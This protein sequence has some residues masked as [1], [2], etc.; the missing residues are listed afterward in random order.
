MAKSFAPLIMFTLFL[1]TSQVFLTQGRNLV[2]KSKMDDMTLSNGIVSSSSP[3]KV[4]IHRYM[5]DEGYTD[6]F[7]PTNPGHSPGIGH[8]KHD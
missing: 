8:S 6:A 3:T 5:L 4:E 1:L 2:A 7:R